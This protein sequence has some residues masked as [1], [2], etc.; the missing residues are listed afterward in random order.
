MQLNMASELRDFDE[1]KIQTLACRAKFADALVS[2]DVSWVSMARQVIPICSWCGVENMNDQIIAEKIR[3]KMLRRG[4]QLSVLS[5][6]D[7]VESSDLSL[8]DVRPAQGFIEFARCSPDVAA[9]QFK[10]YL[11]KIKQGNSTSDINKACEG[12]CAPP[13]ANASASVHLRGLSCLIDEVD[14]LKSFLFDDKVD[15]FCASMKH[16]IETVFKSSKLT[17]ARLNEYIESKA[18]GSD[19][20]SS[21]LDEFFMDQA[22]GQ[23]DKPCE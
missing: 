20:G 3:E 13:F 23:S 1:F 4:L 19:R 15:T 14:L 8:T 18:N 16:R 6:Y 17:S 10:G 11:D 7:L 5:L 9:K 12:I 22:D 21:C 2:N